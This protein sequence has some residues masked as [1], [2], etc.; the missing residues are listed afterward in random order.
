MGQRWLSS[1]VVPAFRVVVVV[2][3]CC[4]VVAARDTRLEPQLLVLVPLLMQMLLLLLVVGRIISFRSK[5]V[6]G[7]LK[8]V[9]NALAMS[10]GC[11]VG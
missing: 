1:A 10:Q 11:V 2:W 7:V 6:V 5:W 3:W 9:E 4:T 8:C